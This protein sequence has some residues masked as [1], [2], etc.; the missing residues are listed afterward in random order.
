[1]YLRNYILFPSIHFL[2]LLQFRVRVAGAYPSKRKA[3]LWTGLWSVAGLYR[4][5]ERQALTFT[6]TCTVSLESQSILTPHMW[7]N[8]GLWERPTERT[9]FQ[10]HSGFRTVKD[11]Y[12]ITALCPGLAPGLAGVIVEAWY[13]LLSTPSLPLHKGMKLMSYTMKIWERS[14]HLM[15]CDGEV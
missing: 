3:I 1:M 4:D 14:T 10:I 12:W 6:S 13:P 7:E 9:V 11:G 2:P 5:R 8:F 15:Q